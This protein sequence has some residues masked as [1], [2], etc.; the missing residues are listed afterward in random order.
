M[1]V[2]VGY[3][4]A[5]F[6]YAQLEQREI[7]Q[8]K[9]KIIW[10]YYYEHLDAWASENG[11]RLPI[12]PESCEH[13]YHIFYLLMPSLEKRTALIKHLKERS[14]NTVFHYLPLHLSSMG[15][16]FSGKKGDYPVTENVS[17]RLIRLPIYND[18]D[19]EA[20]DFNYFYDF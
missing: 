7:I 9:L 13:P 8:C 11:I 17:D 10:E 18:L 14:V 4:L 12:I 2:R 19:I 15:K 20:L 6:L 1:K 3:I 16:K 5:A